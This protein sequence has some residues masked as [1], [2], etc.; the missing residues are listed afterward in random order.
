MQ[1]RT[2]NSIGLGI[3]ALCVAGAFVPVSRDRGHNPLHGG[4]ALDAVPAGAILVASADLAA[5]RGAGSFGAVLQRGREI[6]GVG[7]VKY[8]WDF[9]PIEQIDEAAFAIPAA[10]DMGEFGLVAAGKFDDDAMVQCA[11]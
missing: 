9:D 6:Q 8:I 1:T 7:K 4:R 2:R 10:G 3:A 11:A 5:L